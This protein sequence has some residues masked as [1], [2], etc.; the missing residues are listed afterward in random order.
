MGRALEVIAGEITNA[1]ATLTA[2][3]MFTGDSLQVR[4]ATPGSNI[5]LLALWTHALAAGIVRVH[6]PRLHD[7]VQGIRYRTVTAKCEQLLPAQPKQTL[8]PQDTLVA[9]M[10]GSAADTD[11]AC[12][13]IEYDDLPGISG[14]FITDAD[15]MSRA[16][17]L[18]TVENSLTATAD[19]A[20]TPGEALN[21]EFDLLKANTDYALLGYT[22][23]AITAAVTW[24]GSDTGNLRVGGPGDQLDRVTTANWFR[25]LAQMTGRPC[26]PVFNSANAP[27]ITL[28]LAE[29]SGAGTIIVNT[30]LAQLA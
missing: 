11:Q 18:V 21:A 7:N 28:D 16:Q 3:N 13:L 26:I 20:W 5:K 24:R 29:Q 30:I 19:D 14:R 17:N 27:S 25:Y 4:N 9:E 6:S 2:L 23:N 8:T 15:L 1:G 12:M 22:V 10:S